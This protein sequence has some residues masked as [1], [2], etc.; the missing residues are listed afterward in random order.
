MLKLIIWGTG[1]GSTDGSIVPNSIPASCHLAL[2]TAVMT[3]S[4]L[5]TCRTLLT[6]SETGPAAHGAL[7]PTSRPL[8]GIRPNQTTSLSHF[9]RALRMPCPLQ[10]KSTVFIPRVTTCFG[11][12]HHKVVVAMR[13]VLSD[14]L[15]ALHGDSAAHSAPGEEGERAHE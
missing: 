3:L 4:H 10:H 2:P 12:S 7:E 13:S 6:S 5:S 8:P 15:Q 1:W 9:C 11:I 14:W